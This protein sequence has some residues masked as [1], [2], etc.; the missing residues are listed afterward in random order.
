MRPRHAQTAFL[1]GIV[2]IVVA[3]LAAGCGGS[4][5]SPVVADLGT[6]GT[7]ADTSTAGA[8]SGSAPSSSSNGDTGGATM[9]IGGG[10]ALK[11]SQCMRA[12]GV[13]NFPDPN[14]QGQIQVGSN[15]GIDSNSATVR[16]AGQACLKLVDGGNGP[17]PTPAE[18]AKARREALAFSVCMR[19]HGV[20]DYPDPNF[21]GGKITIHVEANPSSDLNPN[22]PTLQAAEQ[23]C[24][25]MLP[26]RGARASTS[27]GAK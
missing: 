2:I 9:M 11:F 6:T 15:S 14:S 18:Q 3:L 22:S 12:H 21:S 19:K 8:P 27:G 26:F 1:L 10:D 17:Q 20:P 4:G 13:K 5:D 7:T 16:S 25:G 23:A 24:Q